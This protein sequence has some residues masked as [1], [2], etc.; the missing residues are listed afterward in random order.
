MNK[1]VLVTA[2]VAMVIASAM[3]NKSCDRSKCG[4]RRP[5]LQDCRRADHLWR[6]TGYAC[7]KMPVGCYDV[8]NKHNAFKSMNECRDLCDKYR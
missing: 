8:K 2:L 1:L 3:C 4:G 5:V 6:W 7:E